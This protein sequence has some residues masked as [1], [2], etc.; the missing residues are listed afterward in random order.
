MTIVLLGYLLEFCETKLQNTLDANE[1]GYDIC[2]CIR[3]RETSL[4]YSFATSMTN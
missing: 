2:I 3:I 1:S 4:Y